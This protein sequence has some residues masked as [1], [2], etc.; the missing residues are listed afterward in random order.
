MLIFLGL[1]CLAIGT[2]LLSGAKPERAR[3]RESVE[4]IVG[5]IPEATPGTRTRRP[6]QPPEV[7]ALG[8][9][10]ARLALIATPG[11]R[12]GVE[13]KLKRAGIA[14]VSPERFLRNKALTGCFGAA[15]GVL[16][17]VVGSPALGFF[18]A[19]LFG[20]GGFV[21][22][23][24]YLG[25]KERGHVEAVEQALPNVL[26]ILAVALSAGLSLDM[27]ISMVTERTKGPLSDELALTLGELRM[28]QSRGEALKAL[29][30]R[31]NIAEV[32]SFANAVMQGDR[33]GIP[34]GRILRSLASE[35][36]KRR[37]IAAEEHANKM[38]VKLIFPLAFFILPS[39]LLITVGPAFVSF[40]HS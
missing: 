10:L 30:D 12:G 6:I 3:Q 18:A 40:S 31:V 35:M 4:R 28:G 23:E 24:F 20:L 15:L 19:V 17:M 32:S 13:R 39:L 8:A 11:G 9:V 38:P 36:R 27:A 21:L 37:Q 7:G 33:F 29:E 34:L 25:A 1:A 16:I 2:F 14:D 26:D 22:P 5:F